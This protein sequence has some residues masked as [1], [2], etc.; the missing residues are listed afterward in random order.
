MAILFSHWLFLTFA[1]SCNDIQSAMAE[2]QDE[3]HWSTRLGRLL[4]GLPVSYLHVIDSSAAL[5]GAVLSRTTRAGRAAQGEG[6]LHRP[7]AAQSF[8][9][10]YGD[11]WSKLS[12]VL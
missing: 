2:E 1:Q 11:A 12:D 9:S 5:A 3:L 4:P 7:L 8:Q 10:L 6:S